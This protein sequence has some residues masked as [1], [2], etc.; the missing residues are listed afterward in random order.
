MSLLCHTTDHAV[1]I[2]PGKL[3]DCD[4]R[5]AT[6][7]SRVAL[8]LELEDGDIEGVDDGVGVGVTDAGDDGALRFTVQLP[9]PSPSL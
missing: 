7:F 8:G 2:H 9:P 5:W 3:I 4:W 6:I 1:V